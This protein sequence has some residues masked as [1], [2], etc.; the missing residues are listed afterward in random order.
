MI[1]ATA[2]VEEGAII[3]TG[4]RIWHFVHIRSG[5]TIG[6]DCVIGKDCYIDAGAMIGDGVHIQ[7]GVSIY[8]GVTLEDHVFVGPHAVFTND[9]YPRT[10]G[11][12]TVTPTMVRVGASIGANATILCG[13]EIGEMAM[14]GAGSV[15]TA[16]VPPG[17]LVCGNPATVRGMAV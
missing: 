16:D 6:R 12:W 7:N 14:V 3:G 8:N 2:I 5:A 13:I 15:V 10:G 9:R 1:H 17:M 11:V 4:T